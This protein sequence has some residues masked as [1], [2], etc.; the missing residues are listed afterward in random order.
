MF[1][2]DEVVKILSQLPTYIKWNTTSV[3]HVAIAASGENGEEARS[4]GLNMLRDFIEWRKGMPTDYIPDSGLVSMYVV[5]DLEEIYKRCVNKMPIDDFK[6][7]HPLTRRQFGREAT[8]LSKSAIV[9]GLIALT[10]ALTY[11]VL[12]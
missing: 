10:A 6:P 12:V 1:T 4:L 5:S 7:S 8:F 2:N 9:G 11:I 3:S